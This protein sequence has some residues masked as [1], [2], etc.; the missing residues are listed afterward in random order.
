MWA[1]YFFSLFFFLFSS[2]Y[3]EHVLYYGRVSVGATRPTESRIEYQIR[4]STLP[5]VNTSKVL[6][7]YT[8]IYE[9]LS[10]RM[11]DAVAYERR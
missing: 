5:R 4:V 7:T 1:T 10:H 8:S 6:Y 3:R 11:N 2:I 9:Y